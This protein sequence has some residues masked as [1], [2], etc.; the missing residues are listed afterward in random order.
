MST[1]ANKA[2]VRRWYAEFAQTYHL[3]FLDEVYAPTWAG[4]LPRS[5]DL[6]GAADHKRVA[7]IFQ[8]AFPD[9]QYTIEDLVAEGDRVVSRY[10]MHATHTGEMLGI[11]P[12]GKAV[13][14]TGINIHRIVDGQ[15]VEQWAQFDALGMLQQFGVLSAPD[16]V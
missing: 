8:V 14:V 6:Q 12:T 7:R 15:F 5:G 16:H 9:A 1:E 13:T 4:H 10:T 2:L 3:D 11:P